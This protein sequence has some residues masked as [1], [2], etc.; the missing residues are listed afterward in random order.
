MSNR[1]EPLA[2]EY[3]FRR[4]AL[5]F[6]EAPF[7]SLW[8]ASNTTWSDFTGSLEEVSGLAVIHWA[9]SLFAYDFEQG[10]CFLS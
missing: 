10:A 8:L 3:R 5:C 7:S 4:P 6:G 2:R 9:K 1:S